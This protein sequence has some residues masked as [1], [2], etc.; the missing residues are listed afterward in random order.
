MV[1]FSLMILRYLITS[2]PEKFV[3]YAT[4]FSRYAPL[5][6]EPL[7]SDSLISADVKLALLH[8]S[9]DSMVTT[10]Y[11]IAPEVPTHEAS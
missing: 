10:K 9:L 3:L 1:S 4:A 5:N 7:K 6:V 8:Q 2:L 11:K